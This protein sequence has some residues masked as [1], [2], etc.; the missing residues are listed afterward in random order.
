LACISSWRSQ[1]PVFLPSWEAGG[2]TDGIFRN[3]KKIQKKHV[4]NVII[5]GPT[6]SGK[7]KTSLILAEKSGGEIISADSRQIYKYM[8]IG[9]AKPSPEERRRVPHHLIDILNPDER[10]TAAGFRKDAEKIITEIK[11][12]GK[13]PIIAG[14]TGLYIKSLV[15]GICKAPGASPEIRKKLE[16]R[17]VEKGLYNLYIELEQA[18]RKSALTIHP[19]D[20]RRI[21]RALELFHL[22]GQPPSELRKWEKPNLDFIMIGIDVP[23]E[24][25]YKRINT[26]VDDMF[27]EGFI[28]E[29]EKLLEMGYEKSL[30]SMEAVGYKEIIEYIKGRIQIGTA[31]ENT[32]N[33]TRKYARRQSTWF[34]KDKRI[35]WLESDKTCGYKKLMERI[36]ELAV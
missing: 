20:K 12:R 26:R 33:A 6:C 24:T 36:L 19:N 14:G 3:R 27:R 8:D 25:L 18:D 34:R 5:T 23:R 30:V 9:T 22:T 31:V 29:V 15:D 11:S 28:D 10:Y 13:N 21:I 17:A 4:K 1:R 35:I 16:E 32:K 2:D 7:T